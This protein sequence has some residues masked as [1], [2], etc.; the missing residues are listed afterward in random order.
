MSA[1]VHHSL[2]IT[3]RG[4]QHRHRFDPACACGWSG[5]HHRR[6]VDAEEE[7]RQ[8]TGAEEKRAIRGRQGMS[9]RPCTPQED[10]PDALR[11]GVTEGDT[12]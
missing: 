10:L 2:T 3:D 12:A 9:P 8:H 6:R 11:V 1:T 4:T 5:R 7:Y